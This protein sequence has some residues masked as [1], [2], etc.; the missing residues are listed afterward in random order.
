M[1]PRSQWHEIDKL[2]LFIF[3][4]G[5]RRI[6][7]KVNFR[8]IFNIHQYQHFEFMTSKIL[9]DFCYCC[10]LF[11]EA[12]RLIFENYERHCSYKM[13]ARTQA[14]LCP[15]CVNILGIISMP[16]I[17]YWH[18]NEKHLN[19]VENCH[20][21]VNL[22]STLHEYMLPHNNRCHCRWHTIHIFH[23]HF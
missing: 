12:Y 9:I 22:Q 20:F 21:I 14:Q 18:L 11:N 8:S 7:F 10:Y 13:R 3:F 17:F 4:N 19:N 15:F 6:Q 5:K 23:F 16:F 1:L 2:Y